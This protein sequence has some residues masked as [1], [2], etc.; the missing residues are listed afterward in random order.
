M[1]E[2]AL[3]ES[4]IATVDEEVRNNRLCNV[5][6]VDVKVGELQQIDLD[7]FRM[8]LDSALKLYDLPLKMSQISVSREKSVLKCRV[9]ASEWGFDETAGQLAGDEGEAIHFIPEVA[10]IYIRCPRCGSP[11]FSVL[12][13]RGVWIASIEG[14]T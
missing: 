9:C 5:S 11:D 6:K 2:W 10:H 7:I 8:V 13:G 12:K 3:A 1:H 4:I 14:E